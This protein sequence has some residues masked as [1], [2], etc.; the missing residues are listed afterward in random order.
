M[1]SWT[2][3]GRVITIRSERKKSRNRR[4]KR[5]TGSRRVST[6]DLQPEELREGHIRPGAPV[7]NKQFCCA[8][9]REIH[10]CKKGQFGSGERRS[11]VVVGPDRRRLFFTV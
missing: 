1:T 5:N 10:L 2:S 11:R 7:L 4:S 6:I 8:E 3:T 9:L